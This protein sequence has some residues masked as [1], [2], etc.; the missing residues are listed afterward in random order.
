MYPV[1]SR[2]ALMCAVLLLAPAGGFAGDQ[3]SGK[4]AQAAG[5]QQVTGVP[6]DLKGWDTEPPHAP[7]GRIEAPY[8]TKTV[9]PINVAN[10]G[11]L[12][13]LM[14]AGNIY[15]SL[16][17]TIALAL[18]NNIDI[19]IQRYGPRVAEVNLMLAKAGG[20][21]RGV[22]TSVTAGPSSSS[23]STSG[24]T[25]GTNQSA[26][27]QASAG[28][29]SAVGG[30][31]LQQTGPSIPS[32]DP[33][34]TGSAAWGHATSPQSSAFTTGTNALISTQRNSGAAIQKGFL[35][36]TIVSLGLNNSS[37]L[38]NSIRADFNPAT[39]SSLALAFTQ[40]LLQGFGVA[41]NSRQIY[42]ARNNR[43]VS[44][45]T[46][47]LQVQTTVAAV[48]TLYWDLVAFNEAARV[49]QDASAASQRLLEN[50]RQQ[51]AVGT[52]APIEVTRAEAEIASNEQQ[53]TV[54]QMR[55]LQQETI[56][57]N[58][59]SRTG[60]SSPAVAAA[61]IIPTDQIRVPDVEPVAPIQ[62]LMALALSAR[63]ELA[64]S[65]IQIRNQEL[66]LRGSRNALLPTLDAV[67]NISNN[68]LAG[69]PN[70]LPGQHSN[71]P[72]FIGGYSTV[73]TQ[74]FSRNFP[75]YSAGFSLNVPLRNRSAQAQAIN[76]QLTLRQLQLA[77]QRLENQ[78]RVDVQN[79]LIGL[80][81][82]RG[83]FRAASKAVVLQQQTL[84]AEQKKLELGV[85]TIYNSI[86]AERDLVTAQSN[87]VTADAAYARAKVEM[88]RSTGQLLYNNNISL[89]EAYRG[90]VSRPPTPPPAAAPQNQQQ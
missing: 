66:T 20:F 5:G 16:Q 87:L 32:L 56:I 11:R 54:A 7:L 8:R 88:D 22:S 51:V 52:L 24:T 69:D 38:N 36:G 75:N 82:A 9:P 58:A 61:R 40:H 79:A 21:A 81:Q 6:Q 67:A 78:V 18:E 57:K 85:S 89:G 19:E 1:K 86:L 14:R 3:P 23:V 30:T 26:A 74:L 72:F 28:T 10:S 77:L 46:F 68:A 64:Q 48:M 12:D 15:L 60:I 76:D 43:E 33:M 17:D 55:V 44:D 41:V 25:P 31:V 34:L 49:A 63:P 35:T 13:A 80:T 70:P 50:N 29:A 39:N 47:K 90:R 37:V 42:I 84:G 62:D 53:L 2:I 45:L 4:A 71:S 83:Q 27:S 73:L 65:R 59:L